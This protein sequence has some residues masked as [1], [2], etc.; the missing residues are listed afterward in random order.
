[1]SKEF[2]IFWGQGIYDYKDTK[3]PIIKHLLY[4]NDTMCISSKAGVGKSILALHLLFNLTTGTKFLDTFE[5]DGPKNVLYLQTEGDRAETL[6]RIKA[7]KQGLKVDDE[8]WAHLNLDGVHLNTTDGLGKL[9]RYARDPGIKYDVFMIDPL[10]TT[11][12]GTMVSDEVA[13]DWI[14]NLRKFRAEFDCAVIVLNHSHKPLYQAGK[15]VERETDNV[16]GAFGWGAYFNQQFNFSV[17]DGIHYLKAGK[18]RSGGKIVD[19]VYM[20]MVEPEPLMFIL[21]D[22]DTGL[23]YIKISTLLRNNVGRKYTAKVL[24]DKTGVST[25]S[26]YRAL[27]KVRDNGFLGNDKNFYWWKEG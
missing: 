3:K 10:Y 1:M 12:R 16:F 13:S 5:I 22:E 19:E 26:T 6:E 15:K 24:A 2:G 8:R 14:R 18:R 4:E 20:K 25:A 23:T 27:N 7:M 21:P 17:S 9:V 11:V